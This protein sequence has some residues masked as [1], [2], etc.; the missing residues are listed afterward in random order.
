MLSCKQVAKLISDSFD[1]QLPMRE[2]MALRVHLWMCG[3]CS[4]YLRQMVRLR[5]ALRRYRDEIESM[6]YLHPIKLPSEARMR[7]EEA[8]KRASPTR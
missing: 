6:D 4:C 1:R 5:E 2:R 3:M 7:I 8:I